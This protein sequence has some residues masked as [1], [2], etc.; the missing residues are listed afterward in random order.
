MYILSNDENYIKECIKSYKI[1]ESDS[2]EDLIIITYGSGKEHVMKYTKDAEVSL[3]IIMNNQYIDSINNGQ[4][5]ATKRRFST[6]KNIGAIA[7]TTGFTSFFANLL[8]G[9]TSKEADILLPITLVGF[10]SGAIL[11]E[12]SSKLRGQVE[13]IN[14]IEFMLEEQ[15]TLKNIT[16]TSNTL[17]GYPE[18]RHSLEKGQMPFSIAGLEQH[19]LS[20][21]D[22]EQIVNSAKPEQENKKAYQYT[23]HR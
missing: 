14:K 7:I 9:I 1:L 23:K 20:R 3:S 19:K 15:E 2:G 5:S 13:E 18:V 16:P 22:L 21:I 4:V 17:D 12:R 10:A 11:L 8:P 6:L